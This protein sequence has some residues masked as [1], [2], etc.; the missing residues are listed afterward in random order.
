MLYIVLGVLRE[1]RPVW[2]FVLSF[3]L[4]VLS[5]LDF[6][7][8]NKV[9]CRVRPSPSLSTHR[10]SMADAGFDTQGADHR[11]DGAFAATILETAAVACLFFAWRSITEGMSL[12]ALARPQFY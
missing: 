2:F 12:L 1:V 4:F 8:L 3:V 9:I 11:I 10:E 7:L 5:Q 6:F